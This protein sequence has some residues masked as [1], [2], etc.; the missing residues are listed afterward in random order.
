M[1]RKMKVFFLKHPESFTGRLF[2]RFLDKMNNLLSERKTVNMSN[3]GR[4][5]KMLYLLKYPAGS[6]FA[7]ESAHPVALESDDHKWPRG[8]LYDNSRNRNFNRKVYWYF[9]YKRD[10]KVM[11][12]GCAGGGFVKSFIEDGYEAVGLEGSDVSLKLRSAEWDNIPYHLFTCD[13]SSH[14]SIKRRGGEPVLFDLI[15]AWEML[16]HIPEDRLPVLIDNICRHLDPEGIFVASVDLLPDGDPLR[17]AVYHLT[18]KPKNWWI[19]K[20]EDAGFEWVEPNFFETRDYVR[21][22]GMGLKDW[23]PADGDGFHLVMRK[24]TGT[25]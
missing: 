11:D 1:Y 13:V 8:S 21:G 24:R 12:M 5:W 10:L 15:T 17:G 16:E 19:T 22:H 3:E 9:R 2:F 18:L 4:L 23:D 7:V 6:V 14:F 20:F 25:A